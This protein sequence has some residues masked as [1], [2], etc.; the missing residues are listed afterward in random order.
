MV[1][2][3]HDLGSESVRVELVLEYVC[4]LA[5]VGVY[6]YEPTG[7]ASGPC[8]LWE[9]RTE[10]T[11]LHPGKYIQLGIFELKFLHR[12][13][14]PGFLVQRFIIINRVQHS[15]VLQIISWHEYGKL[16]S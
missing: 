9:D 1:Q 3:A 10:P 12:A 7:K 16:L 14:A 11:G 5:L 15:D 13:G 4:E 8:F 2:F 6:H